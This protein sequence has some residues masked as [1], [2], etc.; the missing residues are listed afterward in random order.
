MMAEIVIRKGY[1]QR[2]TKQIIYYMETIHESLIVKAKT[3]SE[4]QQKYKE[5]IHDMYDYETPYEISTVKNVTF[6]SR[7]KIADAVM[8]A[9][10][11]KEVRMKEI[12]TKNLN[13]DYV[14]EYKDFLQSD[15]QYGTCVID[16]VVGLYQNTKLKMTRQWFINLCK[17]YYN[18]KKSSG[19]DAGLDVSDA[20][21]WDESDGVCSN[22]LLWICQKL[23]ISMYGY[24]V[25][26]QCFI[27]N[28]SKNGSY[29]GLYYFCIN[30]H[31]YL[32]KDPKLK[33]SMSHRALDK[34]DLI[35]STMF[36]EE[37]ESK[38]IFDDLEIYENIPINDISKYE[39]CILMY[40]DRNDINDVFQSFIIE[41]NIVPSKIRAV[42]HK[43]S[44]FEAIVKGIKYYFVVDPNSACKNESINYK[45]VR[46]LCK[47]HDIEFT[48][49]SFTTFLNQKKA[50]FFEGINSRV[51][52]DR[53]FRRSILKKYKF[54][55]AHCNEKVKQGD[56][57]NY[58]IDHIRPLSN[59]GTNDA[60]NLQILCKQ[61]HDDKCESEIENGMYKRISDTE[62]SF[63]NEIT[64]IIKSDLY[65][66]FAFVESLAKTPDGAKVFTIDK[67]KCRTNILYY[68][69]YDL[70]VFS[71]MDKVEKF[72]HTSDDVITSGLYYIESDNYIPLRGNGW[73]FNNVV[74][75][76]LK[77]NIIQPYQIKYVVRASLS[78]KAD[79]YNKFI[80][81]C[82]ST[83]GDL[84]KL[85]INSMI[86][87]FNI[88]IEKNTI[89]KTL[90]VVKGSY[91]S[92][93]HYFENYNNK[94]FLN[95][96]EV[97]GE[98]YYHMFE[99]VAR[100]MAETESP[101]Y[102]FIVQSENLVIH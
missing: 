100:T 11:I 35:K 68:G 40:M 95:S 61:C 96:F 97:N 90:G 22:C 65:K 15:K 53:D 66:S 84:F 17:Q 76:C 52:F 28:I 36:K 69:K 10:K 54:K 101:L 8:K 16:N 64:N 3:L 73:Y 51:E 34:D 91:E 83:L 72:V 43:I 81:E 85:S 19:L 26:N 2:K 4:A 46:Q 20:D 79:Y 30:D 38:N 70:P 67:N 93:L 6:T 33:Q 86:G 5:I 89:T 25:N 88:N 23:D 74:D 41:Y 57:A 13:Y 60:D 80:D 45:T 29:E 12:G 24:D 50:L 94:R 62:S 99:D 59:G 14:K 87:T 32:I 82:R 44:R 58:N 92:Y 55:C 77:Y 9:T 71:V 47:D 98:T 102:N 63:N 1:I 37:F 21:I 78:V 49:Q 7:L 75:Y 27:K 31:M 48:N 56:Y 42:N 18:I 39:S